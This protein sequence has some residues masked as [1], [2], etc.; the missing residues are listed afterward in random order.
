VVNGLQRVRPNDVVK[1]NS[2][3]MASASPATKEAS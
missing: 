2:V 1:P 3:A